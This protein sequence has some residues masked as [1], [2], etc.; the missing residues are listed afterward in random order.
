MDSRGIT[1]NKL[2]KLVDTDYSVADKYYKGNV[3]RLDLDLLARI[4]Y[5]LQCS[6]SDI[7][8]YIPPESNND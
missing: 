5:A 2:S 3:E 4:C 6:V 1:R 7:L 8:M